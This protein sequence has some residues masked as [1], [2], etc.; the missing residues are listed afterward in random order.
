MFPPG[1]QTT[2]LNADGD[3]AW[4]DF[5]LELTSRSGQTTVDCEWIIY[6][7]AE[8][9]DQ[10]SLWNADGT[11]CPTTK[12]QLSGRPSPCN[13]TRGVCREEALPTQDVEIAGAQGWLDEVEEVG[14][15]LQR[16]RSD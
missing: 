8:F 10:I 7:A 12:L 14:P 11:V 1:Q 4:I 16:L 15:I 13:A 9:E 2:Y 6:I 5:A 3:V